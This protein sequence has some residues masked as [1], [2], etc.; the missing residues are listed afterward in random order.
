LL[1]NPEKSV[2]Q[3]PLLS[4]Q[5]SDS[6]LSLLDYTDIR[7]PREQTITSVFAKQVSDTPDN[8]AIQYQGECLTYTELD[9]RSDRLAAFL[10]SKGVRKGSIVG[11]LIGRELRTVIGMLGIL[12]AGG[13]YMPIDIDY[14]E[15]RKRYMVQDSNP[16]LVLTTKAIAKK[17]Q[18]DFSVILFEESEVFSGQLVKEDVADP[19]AMAY[20]IYTSGTTGNPK[21]VMV[22]H[23]NVVRLFFNDNFQF[24]FRSNDIWTMFHSHCFDFSVWEIYG[25][26]LFGGKVIIVPKEVARDTKSYLHLLDEEKV[27]VLNQTPSAFY[28][29][30]QLEASELAPRLSL[31][32]VIFGGEAL[33]P[34]KLKTWRNRYP[35]TRLINMFGITET[36]VHVTYK[37]IGS[38]EIENN[39][40]NIGKPIP[41]LSTYVLDENKLPVPRGLTGEL[42]VGGAGVS[43]GYL[44]KPELTAEKFVPDPFKA[45]NTLYRTGDLVR[46]LTNGELEY[47]GRVDDQIQLRGFRIELGEIEGQLLSHEKI[48]EAVVLCQENEGNKFLVAYYQAEEE[49]KSEHL[50][51]YL[52]ER[53]P[54]YMVP[55]HYLFQKKMALT[56]SGKIDKKALPPFDFNLVDEVVNPTNETEEMLVHI[57]SDILKVPKEKISIKASFFDLGG[58]SLNATTMANQIARQFEVNIPL[59]QIFK[60]NTLD[61]IADY[62]MNEIWVKSEKAHNVE[63]VGT[64][65]F[66]L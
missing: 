57:W 51:V 61:A 2:H 46:I 52:T 50:R 40:S 29:L 19:S 38:Y 48:E 8:I 22:S 54:E 4:K 21:G 60:L 37:E 65:E 23:R 24:E 31:R 9:E 5:E 56:S 49:M 26:L 63:V 53:L 12:K 43:L 10:Q 17:H 41:T 34:A 18:F 13:A 64:E 6:V 14:P 25:A 55:A 3:I 28:N 11:L 47:C 20:I 15:D 59:S 7:Y 30:T 32:Y 16:Y 42:Y 35:E 58:H 27:T 66:I 45:G 1:K 39:I 44:G 62:I 36:T 33:S